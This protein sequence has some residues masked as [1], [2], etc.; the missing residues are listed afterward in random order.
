MKFKPH[1]Q[2][3]TRTGLTMQFQITGEAASEIVF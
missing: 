2:W 3:A 1:M